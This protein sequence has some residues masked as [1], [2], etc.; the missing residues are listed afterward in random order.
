MMKIKLEALISYSIY[1]KQGQYDHLHINITYIIYEII[2]LSTPCS[3]IYHVILKLYNLVRLVQIV[4][5]YYPLLVL[6]SF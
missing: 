5:T 2:P 4:S 1:L 3:W 6:S